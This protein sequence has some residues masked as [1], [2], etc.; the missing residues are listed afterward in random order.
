[1]AKLTKAEIRRA[2]LAASDRRAAS[3]GGS[4][5][6]TSIRSLSY[7]ERAANKLVADWMRKS[8]FDTK[9]LVVL[10]RQRRDELDRA[11]EKQ[12]K[13][14]GKRAS[15]RL[16]FA[17]ASVAS[18][19]RIIQEFAAR[20]G[21]FPFP[22]FTLDRPTVILAEPNV[23]IIVDSRIAPFESSAK[24][25]VDTKRSGIDKLNFIYQWRNASTL[26]VVIDAVTF[27]SASGRLHLSQSGSLTISVGSMDVKA[28]LE[29]LALTQPPI[30]VN[31]EAQ[32]IK[33]IIAPSYPLWVD[34]SSDA[35][36]SEGLNLAATHC[37]IPPETNVLFV[38]SV[39]VDCDFAPGRA[40]ADLATGNFE[41]RCP[42]VVVSLRGQ[43][44]LPPAIL[45]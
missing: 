2:L 38:V 30:S 33:S 23:G 11:L 41:V 37:T 24:I 17:H 27:L 18:K 35:T 43:L 3:D 8:G 39:T 40:V 1:M 14:D 26:S 6:T 7:S 28:K 29:V 15:R 21:F 13:A 25:R 16:D 19:A 45:G 9:T 42:L 10:Q 31:H 4:S 34:G 22:S 36:F 32:F 44:Q 20:G 12:R 5:A